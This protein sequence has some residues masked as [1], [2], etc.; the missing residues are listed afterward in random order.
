MKEEEEEGRRKRMGMGEKEEVVGEIG[1]K[2]E[3]E[4]GE[5]EKEYGG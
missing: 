5:E 2:V 1:R 4:K 3:E